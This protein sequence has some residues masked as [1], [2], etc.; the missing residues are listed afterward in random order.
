MFGLIAVPLCMM[1]GLAIDY[2]LYIQA[3]S[4]LTLAAD[5]AAI[6][7]VR[8]AA[9]AYGNGQTTTAAI[10]AAGQRAGQQW[11]AAQLGSFNLGG[12]KPVVTVTYSP[13]PSMFTAVV[14]YS[15]TY[16]TYFSTLF[17]VATFPL[18][19][20]TTTTI[21]NSYDEIIMLLDNSS[22]MQIGASLS[23]II[24]LERAT[25]CSTQG[26]NENQPMTV[27]SWT[28]GGNY[29]YAS[30]NAAPPSAITGTCD[31]G[32]DGDP[33]ACIYPPSA[34][35]ISPGNTYQ[36]TNG[37]GTPTKV[38]GVNYPNMPNAP[39]AFA[40]HNDPNSNDYYG[41]ARS[42]TPPV[43]LRMD[44]VQQAAANVI[45]T[46]QTEQGAPNQFSVGLYQ[47]TS[48]LQQVY[49]AS[50]S[51]EATT[52]LPGAQSIA[53]NLK[54]SPNLSSN[55]GNTN[56]PAAMNSLN[57]IVSAAGN[58]LSA[59]SPL[60]NLFIVTDGMDNY[61]GIST[62]PMTSTT[63]EQTC[64]MFWQKGFS[65]YVLYTPYS[66]LPNGFY[67]KYDKS[68]AEP[69][70]SSLN[71]AALQACARYPSHFFQ[72]SDPTA[73]NTAMQSML[74]TALNTPGRLSR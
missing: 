31:S 67:I 39:C 25:P 63:N 22:S 13:S 36:C 11:F 34:S 70:S 40:C 46:L 27:Y 18:A 58:G 6:H 60:K 12:V 59:S 71:V 3:Q 57:K 23:D 55:N 68:Y 41:L 47:F 15:G 1:I 42:L 28:Y 43:Q 52:D 37:G 2:S 26:I 61:S 50:G 32:Y 7:A 24:A 53:M 17:N 48:K 5:A 21:T 65:V 45:Q 19:G 64:A 62:G 16:N 30:G 66:P 29:G 51:G 44:V 69:T 54:N 14:T 8:V 49:P 33:S 72:A 4:Q 20:S 74:A 56:F 73:I 9:Q 38:K 35:Y 10:Q